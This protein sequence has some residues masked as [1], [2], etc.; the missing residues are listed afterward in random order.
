M[1][2]WDVIRIDLTD[3]GRWIVNAV[4]CAVNRSKSKDEEAEEKL[5]ILQQAL[6]GS[7]NDFAGYKTW[8]ATLEEGE[9][10]YEDGG[11]SYRPG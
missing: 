11:R 6:K 8:L 1:C 2:E 7:Y 4:E 3:D 5:G 10:R 9:L